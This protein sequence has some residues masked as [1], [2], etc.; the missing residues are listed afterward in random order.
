LYKSNNDRKQLEKRHP[1]GDQ[2]LIEFA[3]LLH[4]F[5]K[6][7][8][9]VSRNGGEEFSVICRNVSQDE[10][11]RAVSDF[12]TIVRNHL[13][14]NDYEDAPI[15]LTFSGGIGFTSSQIRDASHLL[16][17][18]DEALYK[19]KRNGRDQFCTV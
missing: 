3:R 14:I 13:F 15:S 12:Q 11:V 17:V 5:F 10:M 9:I 4:S 8:G 7:R 6:D 2:I 19:A 1:I 18:T 16:K